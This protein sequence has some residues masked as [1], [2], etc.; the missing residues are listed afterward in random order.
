MLVIVLYNPPPPLFSM[1]ILTFMSCGSS[2]DG[3][4]LV[5]DTLGQN[6]WTGGHFDRYLTT[7]CNR[8]E[9]PVN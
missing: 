8:R 5:L 2:Q 3:T 1:S 7:F 9:A 4:P 6:L